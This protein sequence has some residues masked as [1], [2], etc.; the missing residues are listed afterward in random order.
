MLIR[1]HGPLWGGVTRNLRHV[2]EHR[3]RVSRGFAEH[4]GLTRL[5]SFEHHG[6]I[7]EPIEPEKN[8]KHRDRVRVVA[9]VTGQSPT[10][11]DLCS[12]LL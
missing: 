12:T 1:P 10:W 5:V 3:E 8:N 4:H 9:L 2:W 6:K 11:D 7:V